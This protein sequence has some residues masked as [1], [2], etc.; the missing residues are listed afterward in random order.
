V[1]IR[2][3]R[4]IPV[5]GADL[6]DV[7]AHKSSILG[8]VVSLDLVKAYGVR[9]DIEWSG[10]FAKD[11]LPKEVLNTREARLVCENVSNITNQ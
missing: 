11:L 1:R 6:V 10:L 2:S 5:K 8:G 3:G 4:L 7:V 9:L